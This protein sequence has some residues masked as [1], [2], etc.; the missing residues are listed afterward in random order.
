MPETPRREAGAPVA[1]FTEN[2]VQNAGEASKEHPEQICKKYFHV[3]IIF[4]SHVI[5]AHF[6]GHSATFQHINET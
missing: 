2:P 5:V 4:G 6:K 3:L 1:E